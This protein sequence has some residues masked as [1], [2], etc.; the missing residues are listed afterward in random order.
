MKKWS[1]TVAAILVV[2]LLAWSLFYLATPGVP[3]T[4]A[5]TAVIVGVATGVV[6]LARAVAGRLLKRRGADD[7]R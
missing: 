2:S 7:A 3:L 1:G 6:L 4:A 5:E